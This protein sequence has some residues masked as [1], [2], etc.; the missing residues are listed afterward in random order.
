MKR[1]SVFLF[2]AAMVFSTNSFAWRTP[3]A[4][5]ISCANGTKTYTKACVMSCQSSSWDGKY[6]NG[7]AC[8]AC[9]GGILLIA[10]GYSVA[11]AADACGSGSVASVCVAGAAGAAIACGQQ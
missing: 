9:R 4:D 1:F 8:T 5:A 3:D 11:D 10:A 6:R 7:A 2:F